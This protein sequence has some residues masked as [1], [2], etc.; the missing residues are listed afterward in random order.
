MNRAEQDEL[1]QQFRDQPEW[2]FISMYGRT[3]RIQEVDVENK[4][5]TVST[6]KGLLS[7]RVKD[8]TAIRESKRDGQSL[9]FEALTAGGLITVNGDLGENSTIKASE[10]RVIDD[11]ESGFNTRPHSGEGPAF[12]PVFP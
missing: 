4:T 12:V 8:N 9:T 10:I 6:P 7:A 2:G 3:G 11:T 1:S 5:V